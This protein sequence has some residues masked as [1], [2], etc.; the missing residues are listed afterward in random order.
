[1]ALDIFLGE[2]LGQLL[3]TDLQRGFLKGRKDL[4]G[5]RFAALIA[6]LKANDQS[7]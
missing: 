6:L 4:I 1:M 3:V 7:S 2:L 5:R